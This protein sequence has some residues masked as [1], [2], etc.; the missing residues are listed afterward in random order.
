MI[1]ILIDW[2]VV[3]QAALWLL[4]ALFAIFFEMGSPGFFFFLSFFFGAIIAFGFT[5]ATSSWLLQSLTFVLATGVSFWMLHFWVKRRSKLFDKHTNTNVYALRSKRGFVTNEIGVGKMGR[6]K[7][8]G[9]SWS[10]RSI[11]GQKIKEGELVS[12]VSV[13]GAHLI[14]NKVK[15]SN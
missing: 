11:D 7:I 10:A 2:L 6:V 4:I 15:K 13:K 9:E 8:N 1:D 3:N 14:V 12:V 5:F